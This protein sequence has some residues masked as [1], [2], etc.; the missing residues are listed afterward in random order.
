MRNRLRL[1][2][3]I[4]CL[5][6]IMVSFA[7]VITAANNIVENNAKV[8]FI[9]GTGDDANSGLSPK[10]AVRHL[11]KATELLNGAG[12]TIVFSGDVLENTGITIPAQKSKV[13]FT[14]IYNGKNYSSTLSFGSA[15]NQANKNLV[16][17]S[18]A[19]INGLHINY[20]LK[21]SAGKKLLTIYSGPSLTIGADVVTSQTDENGNIDLLYPSIAI[22]GGNTEQ[23]VQNS[24]LVVHSGTY[25][26][27]IAGNGI[28]TMTTAEVEIFGSTRIYS[29]LQC[30]GIAK[31]VSTV[32]LQIN[33]GEIE[34]LYVDGYSADVSNVNIA[35][36]DGVIRNILDCRANS[37]GNITGALTLCLRNSATKNIECI[38][39]NS[40]H[41]GTR[42]LIID[43][44]SESSAPAYIDATLSQ[45]DY[46]KANNSGNIYLNQEFSMPSAE[47]YIDANSELILTEDITMPESLSSVSNVNLQSGI[48]FVDP[49]N[50]SDVS[51]ART[52]SYPAATWARALASL[53]GKGG[54]VV[55]CSDTPIIDGATTASTIHYAVPEQLRPLTITGK[56]NGRSYN[57]KLLLG[58]EDNSAKI[59]LSF[60][61]E[62]TIEDIGICFNRASGSGTSAEIWSGLSLS[63]A[64]GVET[65]ATGSKN[66]ITIRTGLYNSATTEA[67]LSVLSGDWNYVQGGNSRKNVKKSFLNFGGSAVAQYIQCGG[68][69]TT[70][71]SS[72]VNITGGAVAKAAYV[73][74]YGT[75]S[76]PA[77][78]STSQIV[79]SG[80]E[81]TALYDARNMYSPV[82]GAVAVVFSGNGAAHIGEIN[83]QS[84]KMISGKKQLVFSN[85]QNPV[86][87]SDL[88]AWDDVSLVDSSSVTFFTAYCAPKSAFSI[89]AGSTAYFS[90][91]F[92]S[93]PPRHQGTGNA[94][95]VTNISKSHVDYDETLFMA[96][97]NPKMDDGTDV[98]KEQGM[99]LWDNQLYVF[100]DGGFC[101]VYDLTSKCSKPI[102]SFKL[103][104]YNEGT[105]SSA[106]QNHCNTVMFGENHYT[107][108]QTG[109]INELPLLYVRTGNSSGADNIGYYNRLAVESITKTESNGVVSFSSRLLQTI[110]YSDTYDGGKNIA[111]Y[112]DEHGT[113]YLPAAGFG[114][115]MWLVNTKEN[116]VYMLSAKYRTTYGSVGDTVNYPGYESV[117]DNYY[118]ITKFNLPSLSA[119]EQVVL[120]PTDIIDQFTTDFAAFATQGGTVFDDKIIY[121]FGFGQIRELNPNKILIFDLQEKRICH[122]LIL[123]DSMFAFD[124]IESCVVYGNSLLVNTQGGYI[125][126]LAA[127]VG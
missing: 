1:A 25:Q 83:L 17:S 64:T 63:I 114:A 18:E 110:I 20:N 37:T 38:R 122:E 69:N 31:D 82:S 92:N 28:N 65:S 33:G 77:P 45:W 57:S 127:P 97:E 119:G 115:P 23:M 95:I 90:N 84:K 24:T 42:T 6:A 54:T 19:E 75:A 70:V 40:A 72:I 15:Q 26:Y 56:Y 101:K 125:Y 67:H 87:R 30:G 29:F 123:C 7:C 47:L 2:T 96:L 86:L 105:P 3:W 51:S 39:L 116:A 9:S 76:K 113:A 10:Q 121:T 94:E 36:T 93:E 99:A 16:F 68:T 41:R 8:I 91:F 106:Y 103:G 35:V 59:I 78:M 88:S 74:G 102:A 108:P 89:E 13:I 5:S 32:S 22:R 124:E 58:K 109:A 48:A 117:N 80:G 46:F 11:Q 71:T 111:N 53:N 62:T 126:Q 118:I 43:G 27:L 12:G 14:S 55:V 49:V 73:N 61:S 44:I 60:L 112:N 4:V 107:D 52:P 34:N 79:I 66:Q 85:V 100:H 81:I 98:D 104:S 21:S 50:G 120:T